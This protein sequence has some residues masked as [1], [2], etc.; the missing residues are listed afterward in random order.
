MNAFSRC[1]NFERDAAEG[2]NDREHDR[3]REREREREK[4]VGTVG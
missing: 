1:I 4:R 3:E 2:G